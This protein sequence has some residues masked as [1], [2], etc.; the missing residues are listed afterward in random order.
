MGKR[1]NIIIGIL[2][3]INIILFVYV[4]SNNNIKEQTKQETTIINNEIIGYSTDFTKTIEESIHK[5]VTINTLKESYTGIIYDYKDNIVTI[6]SKYSDTNVDIIF[7]NNHKYNTS[8]INKDN[9]FNIGIYQIE[10]DYN[11]LPFTIGDSNQLKHGEFII[12][13]HSTNSIKSPI[14]SYLLSIV[15]P[16]NYDNK[17]TYLNVDKHLDIK[18]LPTINIDGQLVS[19][20][21]NNNYI[22]INMINI[23]YQSILN[24]TYNNEPLLNLDLIPINKLNNYNKSNLNIQLDYIKGLYIETTNNSNIG[25]LNKD[26]ILSI[27]NIE[28][29]TI[30]DYFNIIYNTIEESKLTFN[31]IRDNQ[32]IIIEYNIN[33]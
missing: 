7:A 23:L 29:N 17:S 6:I 3:I 20:K 2:V 9:K 16:Y 10:V 30:Y 15:K 22:P 1:I 14:S 24:N 28:I 8:C 19:I 5:L 26:I 18:F 4:L 33:D 21:I 12:G 27:N 32:E 31:I 25:L 11:V 13:L